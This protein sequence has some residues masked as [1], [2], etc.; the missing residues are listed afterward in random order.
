MVQASRHWARTQECW[1]EAYSALNPCPPC[2]DSPTAASCP[3]RGARRS[4]PAAGCFPLSPQRLLQEESKAR[5]LLG[6][7]K[8][9]QHPSPE[10]SGDLEAEVPGMEDGSPGAGPLS[11]LTL[12]HA[13]SPQTSPGPACFPAAHCKAAGPRGQAQRRAPG[14]ACSPSYPTV[15]P[16][17][18]KSSSLKL[19]QTGSL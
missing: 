10:G 17:Q 1:T 13:A 16:C 7:Q 8:A 18:M 9:N 4:L 14:G 2:L 15:A 5:E 12:L 3:A 11:S 19:P 6:L